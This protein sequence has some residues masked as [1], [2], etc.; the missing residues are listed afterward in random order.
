LAKN[1]QTAI[2][3]LWVNQS[4][5]EFSMQTVA[6]D[7]GRGK[8]RVYV[9][10]QYDSRLQGNDVLPFFEDPKEAFGFMVQNLGQNGMCQVDVECVHQLGFKPSDLD[11]ETL[12]SLGYRFSKSRVQKS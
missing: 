7:S 3:V 10:D 6:Y 1:K 9:K 8:V 2:I 11:T 12:K 5:G 4:G